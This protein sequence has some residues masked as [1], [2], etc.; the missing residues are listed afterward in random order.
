MVWWV[1]RASPGLDSERDQPMDATEE[2]TT[3]LDRWLND[4]R[5]GDAEA[6]NRLIEHA[7]DRLRSLAR[8][9]LRGYPGVRRWSETDDVLQGAMI[10]LHRSLSH[11]HPDST[12]SFFG[13]AA[14]QI[15]RELIDLARHHYG[16]EG[17]GANHH[18]DSGE[19]VEKSL[20]GRS[21]PNSLI[22]WTNFHSQVDRLSEEQREVFDLLWYKGLTQPEAAEVLGI[23]LA[24]LKR[25][26]QSARLLMH[27][28]MKGESPLSE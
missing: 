23:S 3:D 16:P 21:E 1:E 22:E 19:A 13:L 8:R 5:R 11:V 28:A 26:W 14:T 25:R 17:I 15:R 18:T 12:K 20:D 27:A 6:R 9:M 10:R 4:L 24:T 7:C 2:L